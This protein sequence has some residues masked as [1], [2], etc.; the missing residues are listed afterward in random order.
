M[1]EL[2]PRPD[3]DVNSRENRA[4]STNADTQAKLWTEYE[5]GEAQLNGPC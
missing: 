1:V 5:E 2:Y 4:P 3:S